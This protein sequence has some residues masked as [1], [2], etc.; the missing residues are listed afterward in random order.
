MTNCSLSDS[1]SQETE[2]MPWDANFGDI[3]QKNKQN[4]IPQVMINTS[5]SSDENP[6]QQMH[7]LIPLYEKN[8]S[9]RQFIPINT[10]FFPV[11]NPDFVNSFSHSQNTQKQQDGARTSTRLSININ[12]SSQSNLSN[13]QLE[14]TNTLRRKNYKW[15]EMEDDQLCVIKQQYTDL[16]WKQVAIML[17][18]ATNTPLR[19]A[20]QVSQHWIRVLNPEIQKGRWSVQEDQMLIQ[21]VK[22]C[23]TRN[24][25]DIA[26]LV[27]GRTDIQVRYRLNQIGK[28]LLSERV[29]T[30]EQLPSNGENQ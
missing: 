11:P 6:P 10:D 8:S 9:Q 18:Q 21:A 20:D 3:N 4:S 22:T 1:H 28:R 12:E 16:S 24:W 13:S 19:T 2:F 17:S 30:Q 27:N 5:I 29:L 15:N 25:K 14:N 23:Q 7:R 26:Q